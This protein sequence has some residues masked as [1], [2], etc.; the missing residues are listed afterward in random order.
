MATSSITK[1]FVIK[2]KKV[3]NEFV[4]EISKPNKDEKVKT[5]YLEDGKK[6]LKQYFYR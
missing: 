1:D 3:F 4:E 2:D 5:S 6:L